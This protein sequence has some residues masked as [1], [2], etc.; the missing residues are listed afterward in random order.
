MR[1]S[2]SYL[3]RFTFLAASDIEEL[4]RAGADH[5]ERREAQRVLAAEVTALVHGREEAGRAERAAAVLFTDGV[6]GLDLPTLE[7]ALADA[8]TT[9]VDRADLEKGWTLSTPSTAPDWPRPRRGPE[10]ARPGAV[11]LNG[12]RVVEGHQIGWGD[13]LHGRW[14]L[15]RRGKQQQ[16]VLLVA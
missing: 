12:Q 2:G 11:Y 4:D 8:P 14:I 5:P 9:K 7:S 6:A 3:R 10:A 1:T 13:A 16:H 15:L